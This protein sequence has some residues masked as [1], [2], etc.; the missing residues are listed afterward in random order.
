M[1]EY[2]D[3]LNHADH[4][5]WVCF[6]SRDLTRAEQIMVNQLL[7]W[8]PAKNETLLSKGLAERFN[9]ATE[10]CVTTLHTA[11]SQIFPLFEAKKEV[12]P[13]TKMLGKYGAIDEPFWETDD[14]ALFAIAKASETAAN[15]I[16]PTLLNNGDSSNGVKDCRRKIEEVDALFRHF[17]NAL[18]HGS[19]AKYKRA[20][21]SVYVF[22]DRNQSR[23][24]NARIVLSEK[25]L[26]RLLD[27]VALLDRE[28]IES[29]SKSAM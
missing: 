9:I 25:R 18:A 19:M 15:E 2:P 14:F 17:R 13:F 20:D 29:L 6:D 26:S 10:A 5:G 3:Y 24:V 1:S 7:F 23:R 8:T 27:L 28:G 4:K 21:E 22:Q 16:V 12:G 11:I